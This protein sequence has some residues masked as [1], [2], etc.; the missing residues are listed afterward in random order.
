VQLAQTMDRLLKEENPA[1]L[2]EQTVNT[3]YWMSEIALFLNEYEEKQ[4]TLDDLVRKI[5]PIIL[6]SPE[7][8][9][10]LEMDSRYFSQFKMINEYAE[11]AMLFKDVLIEQII[12][13]KENYDG[14]FEELFES[15][16]IL[17]S[18]KEEYFFVIQGNLSV[19]AKDYTQAEKYYRMALD[20][21]AD[22]YSANLNLLFVYALLKDFKK[23]EEHIQ[24]LLVLETPKEPLYLSIANSYLLMGELE[25]SEMYSEQIKNNSDWDKKVDFYLSTFCYEHELYELA[26]KF[27]E[28]A[29]AQRSENNEVIF[30]YSCCLKALGKKN[31]ALDILRKLEKRPDWMEYFRFTL[32]RDIGQNQE[33]TETLM[34]LPREYFEEQEYNDAVSYARKQMDL[35]LLRH[36][37]KRLT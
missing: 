3:L 22:L 17:L 24:Y 2:D 36:L 30:H 21:N 34:N 37:R 33:A 14:F 7:R 20:V 16:L 31:E 13:L 5:F 29:Y 1:T 4:M 18:K 28:K 25:K 27:A 8:S 6:V 11:E 32:L 12:E 9:Y 10:F 26:L 19:L 35:S 23:H 15:Y